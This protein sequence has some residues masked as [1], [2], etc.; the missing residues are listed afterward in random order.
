MQFT[1]AMQSVENVEEEPTLN[2]FTAI[3]D[4]CHCQSINSGCSASIGAHFT[5][6]AVRRKS[7]LLSRSRTQFKNTL[8]VS[9]FLQ[10]K[11]KIYFLLASKPFAVAPPTSYCCHPLRSQWRTSG[12]FKKAI[13]PAHDHD[14][15][16]HDGRARPFQWEN[17]FVNEK[18]LT[19]SSSFEHFRKLL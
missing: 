10:T 4:A 8:P 7:G 14:G 18:V 13:S 11:T 19:T 12:N 1:A 17:F 15:R 2:R 6:P 9:L 3:S 5:I 16:D